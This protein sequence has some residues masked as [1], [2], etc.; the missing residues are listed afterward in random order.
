MTVIASNVAILHPAPRSATWSWTFQSDQVA[1]P[2]VAMAAAEG[3]LQSRGFSVGP[4]QADEPRGIMFG[5]F[6]IAKWR[7]LAPH[8]R[9]QLH[10]VMTGD[11]RFGPVK[12]ELYKSA[13]PPARAAVAQPPYS[14]LP[15]G[16]MR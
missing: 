15:M 2:F 7:D 10:G 13:T 12:I 4:M 14:A 8:E 9:H 6:I 16:A 3:F 1:R 11:M 5:N